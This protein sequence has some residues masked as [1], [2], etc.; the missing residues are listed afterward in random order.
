M[1]S[2]PPPPAGAAAKNAKLVVTLILCSSLKRPNAA[3]TQG[4]DTSAR[5]EACKKF[6][7]PE[8]AWPPGASG[9]GCRT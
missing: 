2:P 5:A 4:T 1:V 6:C 8:L 7:P 9:S 3:A